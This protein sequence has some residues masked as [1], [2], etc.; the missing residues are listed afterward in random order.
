M[1]VL[2]T[3]GSPNEPVDAPQDP[4]LTAFL[5][6]EQIKDDD[7]LLYTIGVGNGVSES[8]LED[9]SSSSSDD[10]FVFYDTYD[11]LLADQSNISM[12]INSQ[13]LASVP[14]P[15]SVLLL[16]LVGLSGL[17]YRRRTA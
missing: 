11:D 16:G 2:I 14:E 8:F 17:V 9:I 15:S 7:I 5:Q 4:V 12:F 6:A 13:G 3:D 1:I 10:F